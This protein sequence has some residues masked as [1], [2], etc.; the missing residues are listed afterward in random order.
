M[1][2]FES[3]WNKIKNLKV[4]SLT[5]CLSIKNVIVLKLNLIQKHCRNVLHKTKIS[6]LLGIPND[7]TEAERSKEFSWKRKIFLLAI[8]VLSLFLC[9]SMLRESFKL[10][11]ECTKSGFHFILQNCN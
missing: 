10:P 9:D 8:S 4:A 5:N 11:T 7:I 1:N 6:V 3:A 2:I